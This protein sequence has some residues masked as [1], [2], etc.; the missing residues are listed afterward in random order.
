MLRISRTE[1]PGL[2]ITLQLEGQ[3]SGP[4]LE[5][6]RQTCEQILAQSARLSLDL[7]AVSFVSIDGVALLQSLSRRH[8]V[9]VNCPPFVAEQL[10]G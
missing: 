10:K 9:L 1:S 5:E 8:V 4:W 7:S 6:L 2:A 3:V